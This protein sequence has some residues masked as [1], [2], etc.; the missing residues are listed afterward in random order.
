MMI[1]TRLVTREFHTWCFVTLTRALSVRSP[2]VHCKKMPSVVIISDE[3]ELGVDHRPYF[4]SPILAENFLGNPG[5]SPE[6]QGLG[7]PGQ[8]KRRRSIASDGEAVEV[9]DVSEAKKAKREERKAVSI[10]PVPP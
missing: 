9:E 5:S 10:P 4:S 2:P 7:S 8:R 3:Q 6:G 1:L